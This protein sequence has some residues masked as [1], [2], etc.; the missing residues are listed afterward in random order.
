[1]GPCSALLA[2]VP[3]PAPDSLAPAGTEPWEGTLESWEFIHLFS[4]TVFVFE[5]K[6]G[7]SREGAYD[8]I[9]GSPLPLIPT[10]SPRPGSWQLFPAP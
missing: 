1:M 10:P 6:V 3:T 8:G 7:S 9:L 2:L 4:Q 5:G